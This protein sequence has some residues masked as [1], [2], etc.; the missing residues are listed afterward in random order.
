MNSE[1]SVVITGASS[2]IGYSSVARMIATGWTVFATVRKAEDAERLKADFGERVTPLLVDVTDQRTIND[3][4]S[5]LED[6]LAGRGLDGLVN[7][8]GIGMMRPLE[9]ATEHDLREIFEINVF[10]Q[11]AITQALLPL[12]RKARGRVVNITSVGTHLTIPFGGL[13]NAS[14]SAF[15]A[16]SNALRVE[17]RPFGL[18]VCVI[19]PGAINTPAVGKTLGDVEGV[20]ARLPANGAQQYGSIL[21]KF[22]RRAYAMESRGS[23]PAV[24]ARAVHHALTSARPRVRYLAGKHARVLTTLPKLLPTR[25][26][27]ALIWRML[28]SSKPD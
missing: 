2:G 23:S 12:L 10:G 4:K 26:M 18:H 19:E 28:G 8:A 5:K 14:K 16:L 21:R 20:I 3:A 11:I 17:L 6:Q 13:L 27:D 15:A 1:K 22:A 25:V 24:V 7:V 9:Y